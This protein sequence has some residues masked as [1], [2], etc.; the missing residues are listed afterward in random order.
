MKFLIKLQNSFYSVP[1]DIKS[2]T[3]YCFVCLYSC[4]KLFETVFEI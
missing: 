3:Y 2:G 4:E 1:T